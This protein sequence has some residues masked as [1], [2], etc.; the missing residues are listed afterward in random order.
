MTFIGTQ[1]VYIMHKILQNAISNKK[2]NTINISECSFLIVITKY[3]HSQCMK[4]A[5][6]KMSPFKLKEVN[7]SIALY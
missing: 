2:I 5:I 6:W 7:T 1:F 4:K 3:F